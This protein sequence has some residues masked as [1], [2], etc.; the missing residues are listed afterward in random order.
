MKK[1]GSPKKRVSPAPAGRG[2]MSGLS[3]ADHAFDRARRAAFIQDILAP[4]RNQPT[5]LLP[6]EEVRKTLHLGSQTYLGLR[7]VPLDQIVGSVAR[8]HDFSRAFRPRRKSLRERWQRA[9]KFQGRLP[10]IDVYKVGEVYFVVDG[11]HRVSVA[12]EAGAQ[13]IA[14][15]VWE[16]KTRVPVESNDDLNDIFIR[17]EY[18][19]FLAQSHLDVNRPEQRIVF[20]VPGRYRQLGEAIARHRAWLDGQHVYTVS[21]EEAAADWFDTIYM[22]MEK[23]IRAQNALAEFPGRTAADLVAY[24]LRYRGELYL[25][26]LENPPTPAPSLV[27]VQ[28]A[29]EGPATETARLRSEQAAQLFVEKTRQDG[30]GRLV[31]WIKRHILRWEV[32]DEQRRGD[33]S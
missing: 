3:P 23:V 24:I 7:Q 14:A 20:T 18:L 17:Q 6:F 4:L 28:P 16:Y 12:R 13:T 8:Y 22:P 1:P 10:P 15:H 21:F 11:N 30:W 25:Q 2:R 32:L 5:D 31:A 19:E 9:L 27:D 26:W 33:P 29:E